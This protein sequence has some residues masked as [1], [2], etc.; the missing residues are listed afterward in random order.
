MLY[1]RFIRDLLIPGRIVPYKTCPGTRDPPG[2][3]A[4]WTI[5][6]SAGHRSNGSMYQV[7]HRPLVPHL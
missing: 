1:A 5:L 2:E 7:Q 3:K 6:L 4:H